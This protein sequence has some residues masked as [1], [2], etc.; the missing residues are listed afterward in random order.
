[1]YIDLYVYIYIKKQKPS[2]FAYRSSLSLS[3]QK[4]RSGQ[5]TRLLANITDKF[6]V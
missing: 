5:Y 4:Q 3:P 1:M 2:F 6:L